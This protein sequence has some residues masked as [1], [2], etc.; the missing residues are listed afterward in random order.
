MQRE[1]RAVLL[2]GSVEKESVH[3]DKLREMPAEFLLEIKVI[4]TARAESG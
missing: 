2:T 4:E 3:R 1:Q